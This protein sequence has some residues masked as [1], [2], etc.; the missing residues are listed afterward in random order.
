[1]ADTPEF[2]PD[3]KALENRTHPLRGA[4]LT[5]VKTESYRPPVPPAEIERMKERAEEAEHDAAVAAMLKEKR[6]ARI[7]E[8]RAKRE[9]EA[10]A[11]A[12]IIAEAERQ[13]AVEREKARLLGT[14]R[15]ADYRG[16]L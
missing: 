4:L 10:V 7:A 8:E 12:P 2:N 15:T 16:I 3:P 9:A 13:L 14:D 6:D 1:M 11:R 5:E